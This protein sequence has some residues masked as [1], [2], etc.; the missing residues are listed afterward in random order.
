M[1]GRQVPTDVGVMQINEY[2][3]GKAAQKLGIDL[4]TLDGNLEYAKYL[5]DTQGTN[6]WSASAPCWN[7]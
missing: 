4:H 1:R 5:Y 6:P 3:H 7:R 2:Y